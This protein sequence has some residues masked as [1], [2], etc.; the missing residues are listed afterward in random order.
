MDD[1]NGSCLLLVA[2]GLAVCAGPSPE[3][4][5]LISEYGFGV[6]APSFNPSEIAAELNRLTAKDISMM[7]FKALEARTVLNAEVEMGKLLSLYEQLFAGGR[8]C[9]A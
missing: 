9:A 6:V 8:E 7:K 4:V 2:A 3:M 5:R 1:E